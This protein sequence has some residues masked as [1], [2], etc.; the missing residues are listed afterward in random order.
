[1]ANLS[2]SKLLEYAEKGHRQCRGPSLK[3]LLRLYGPVLPISHVVKFLEDS[4]RSVR[5][6]AASVAFE[7]YGELEDGTTQMAST[8]LAMEPWRVEQ[9]V[10]AIIA[11]MKATKNPEVLLFCAYVRFFVCGPC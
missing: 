3:L 1:M 9:V 5:E 7:N 8:I 6:E 2:Y 10:S 11:D 4:D